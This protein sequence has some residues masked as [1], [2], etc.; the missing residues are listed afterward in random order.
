MYNPFHTS[1]FCKCNLFL[2]AAKS[3]IFSHLSSSLTGL[4]TLR[5]HHCSTIFEETF[6]QLQDIHSSVCY[7]YI[8]TPRWLGVTVDWASVFYVA[9]VTYICTAL[10]G[11]K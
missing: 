6:H 3:P 9:C 8:S 2:I 5:A 4:T 7:L 11:S 1:F 10:K